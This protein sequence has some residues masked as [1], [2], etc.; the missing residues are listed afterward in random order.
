M[1]AGGTGSPVL[2]LGKRFP[3]LRRILYSLLL[4]GSLLLRFRLEGMQGV[5]AL[6]QQP[7]AILSLSYPLSPIK[8]VASGRSRSRRSASVKSL[9]CPWL[10]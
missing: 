5:D 7:G 3:T 1:V 6:L 4:V 10:R 8:V 9:H 2:Q